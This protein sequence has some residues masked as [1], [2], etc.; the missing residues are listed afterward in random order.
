MVKY[1]L[2]EDE[3]AQGVFGHTG[4]PAAVIPDTHG[5]AA[6]SQERLP[7]KGTYARVGHIFVTLADLIS[8]LACGPPMMPNYCSWEIRL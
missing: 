4:L 7:R 1:I 3:A 2:V 8:I 5:S 6:E